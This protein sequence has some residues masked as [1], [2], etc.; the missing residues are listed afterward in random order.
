MST[1]GLGSAILKD[2]VIGRHA[3]VLRGLEIITRLYLPSTVTEP[4][5]HSPAAAE[6][7][8]D[9]D[10]SATFSGETLN[11]PNSQR[12]YLWRVKRHYVDAWRGGL[13]WLEQEKRRKYERLCELVQALGHGWVARH[14][15]AE[16]RRL[17]KKHVTG[18]K[19]AMVSHCSSTAWMLVEEVRDDACLHDRGSSYTAK[20]KLLS[21]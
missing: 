9:G 11:R 17:R 8:Q 19:I 13:A 2:S 4:S 10:Q 15:V 6:T 18:R 1:R 21:A 3:L 5:T 20:W 14:E 16:R 12:G 7:T